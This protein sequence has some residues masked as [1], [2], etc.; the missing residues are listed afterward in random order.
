[1]CGNN[2]VVDCVIECVD[3]SCSR[4]SDMGNNH[5]QLPILVSILCHVSLSC[6]K[7]GLCEIVTLCCVVHLPFNIVLR[8]FIFEWMWIVRAPSLIGTLWKIIYQQLWT[9][10]G[11]NWR[12]ASHFSFS[13]LMV[14]VCSCKSFVCC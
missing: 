11:R 3:A 12:H 6:Q 9:L 13:A 8:S 4:I 10:Q 14:C 1:M 2:N 5:I 7:Y